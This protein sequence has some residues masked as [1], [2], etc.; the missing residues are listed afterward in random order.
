M[1][2]KFEVTEHQWTDVETLIQLLRPLQ[3]MTTVFCG[4]KYCSSSMVRPLLNV[5]IQKH[6]K[7]NISDDEISEHFKTTVIRELLDRFKLL[8]CHSSVVSARQIAS[9]LD[10]RFKDLEH[11]TVEAREEIRKEDT[12]IKISTNCCFSEEIFR[13]TCNICK[14]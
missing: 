10:S 11:E 1:A 12:C 13:D 8:W 4:E 7:P 9:F 2:H 3:I 6:L 14:F 5:V